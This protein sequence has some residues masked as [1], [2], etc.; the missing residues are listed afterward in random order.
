[1]SYAPA[2]VAFV[3][4]GPGWSVSVGGGGYVGWFPLGPHDPFVPWWTRP[5]GTPFTV[6]AAA[7]AN[8]RYATIVPRAAFA[9]A[10]PVRTARVADTQVV[11]EVQAAPVLRAPLPVVPTRASLRAASA[12]PAPRP[13]ERVLTR[14]VAA[15]LAPPPAPP[16]FDRKV[17][18]IRENRGA[19]V[20]PPAA[21]TLAAASPQGA[22]AAVPIRPVVRQD[23][24]VDLAPQRGAEGAPPPD[25][26]HRSGRALSTPESPLIA[27]PSGGREA[28]PPLRVAPGAVVTPAPPPAR[29][30]ARRDAATSPREM[31]APAREAAPPAP[32]AAQ[33][34]PRAAE[35][36]AEV[37]AYSR[38]P[39]RVAEPGPDPLVQTPAHAQA[40][41]AAPARPE[42]AEPPKPERPKRPEKPDGRD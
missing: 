10:R 28:A 31:P 4:G 29:E 6:T 30:V 7:Y 40:E 42:R 38:P 9:E 16:A 41:R 32:Q 14:P 11:R 18:V 20:A 1:V 3:A 21:S 27:H 17:E 35:P 23:R 26:V 8:R 2:L 24:R 33:P 13:P 5:S 15:R 19:P 22:R 39:R 34:A 12:A 37:H 25:P 36:R